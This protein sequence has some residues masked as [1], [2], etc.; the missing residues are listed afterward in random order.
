MQDL[1]D[2]YFLAENT[3][4]RLSMGKRRAKKKSDHKYGS[5]FEV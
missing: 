2:R 3:S 4:R 1:A 5:I